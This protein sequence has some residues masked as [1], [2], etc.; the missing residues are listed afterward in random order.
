[1]G[2][3][4]VG[5]HREELH[6]IGGLYVQTKPRDAQIAGKQEM[7]RDKEGP[8]GRSWYCRHIDIRLLTLATL[9]E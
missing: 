9:R 6:V 7:Q 4:G 1:M 8:S 3:D 2:E 5:T